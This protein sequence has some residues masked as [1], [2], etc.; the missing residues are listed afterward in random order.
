MASL[1]AANGGSGLLCFAGVELDLR[2]MT[3]RRE[4]ELVPVEPQ[5]FDVLRHLV[6]NRSRVVSKE[7]LLD[8]VWGNRFVSESALTSRVRSARVAV[9]D[10]GQRQRVIRTVHGR[11]YQFVAEITPPDS[12][13]AP[14]EQD[15]LPAPGGTRPVPVLPPPRRAIV[16][17][18]ELTA[19][20]QERLL[21]DRLLT[22]V[23][24]AGV[25]KT[26]VAHHVATRVAGQFPDGAWLVQL[27]ETRV[28]DDVGSHILGAIGSTRFPSTTAEET[29]V[30]VL[31]ERHALLVLD[32]CEH[33]LS[34]VARL[35]AR[36]LVPGGPLTILTTSRQ[37]LDVPG[38]VVLAVPVL[39]AVH[40]VALFRERA[41][42]HGVVLGATEAV[43]AVC[44][45]L[46]QL[47]LA[48]ELACAQARVLGVEQLAGLLDQRLHLLGA[49]RP[50]D[51][52][53]V[54]L[55]GAIAASFSELP[56]PHQETLGR[57]S[58]MAGWFDLASA[59]SVA[60]DGRDLDTISAVR[61]VVALAERSLVDVDNSRPIPRYRLLES[62]RLFA[63]ARV[64]D[65]EAA[66][67]AHLRCFRD[68]ALDRGARLAGSEVETAFDEIRAD[69]THYRTAVRYALELDLIDEALDILNATV[70]YAEVTLSMEHGDWSHDVLARAGPRSDARVLEALAGRARL[71]SF[72]RRLDEAAVLVDLAGD[73]EGSYSAALAHF[74][75]AGAA[76]E[77]QDL[78]HSLSV[79]ENFVAGTGGIRELTVG[80]IAQLAAVNPDI[81]P[82]P[83]SRRALLVSTTT[84][85]IGRAFGLAVE[86]NV[87]MR[88]DHRDRAL[89]ACE[90]CIDLA[91][92]TS[93]AVLASQAYALRVRAVRWHE[94]ATLVGRCSLEA[95]R[96]YRSHGHWASARNDAPVAARV[97]AEAGLIEVA[98]DILDGYRPVRYRSVE[99]EYVATVRKALSSELGA[100]I[101]GL[102]RPGSEEDPERFCDFVIQALEQALERLDGAP[103]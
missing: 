35:V 68:R 37:R 4:G 61:H 66:R 85:D 98:A 8:E 33:V 62:I 1:A 58:Q 92:K 29:L 94:S 14:P 20:L 95:M 100:G 43:T 16:D 2:A 67:R 5:V 82:A 54:T 51:G 99:P 78:A 26:L 49:T 102:L 19:D 57:L 72:E 90:A 32:N 28:D 23:G 48:L 52:S 3:V 10:D 44:E 55:E 11:G 18:V 79:L 38:E 25:G 27:A 59:T 13:A 41:A 70:D 101:D 91:R 89:A 24:P 69:W 97:V 42:E 76:G 65:L 96:Y 45:S 88:E 93:L 81:D 75:R 103:A 21:R 73:A 6:E 80:A 56:E 7:E 46:D 9:G 63:E 36:L 83:A 77:M 71:L 39:D 84:G 34:Q 30:S 86:A 12:R 22:L 64:D 15:Q 53:H 50:E 17:R 47:P 40:G 87:A 74:W 31:P 60:A